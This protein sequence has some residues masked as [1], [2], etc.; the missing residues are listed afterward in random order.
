MRWFAFITYRTDAG[1]IIVEHDIE[2]LAELQTLV[3]RGPD[4][5][6]IVDIRITLA[7]VTS[8]DLTIE[9]AADL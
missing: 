3:E 9:Q 7:R 1:P 6:T 2:E 5:N 4:W 8:P